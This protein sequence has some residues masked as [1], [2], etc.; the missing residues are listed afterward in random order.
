LYPELAP[1]IPA[2]LANRSLLPLQSG[3]SRLVIPG[4]DLRR[5]RRR[6]SLVLCALVLSMLACQAVIP[7]SGT[8]RNDAIPPGVS[9]DGPTAPSE[10]IPTPTSTQFAPFFTVAAVDNLNLRVHPG[11]LGPVLGVITEQT[12][13]LVIHRA[14]GGQWFLIRTANGNEGWVF[15][16]LLKSDENLQIAP[17][18]VPEGVQILHGRLT[19][20]EGLPIRGAGFSVS[21]GSGSNRQVDH[22]MT[23]ADGDFYS[24]LP[25]NAAG[26]WAIS[27]DSIA[28]NSSVW[29]G[30]NCTSYREGYTGMVEPASRE[31][32]LPQNEILQ[33]TWR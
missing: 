17:I 30:S 1:G 33:F 22:V 27:Y 8:T 32:T 9:A 11:Y 6:I 15:G 13:L 12:P 21:Q 16:A 31:V 14:P 28:C 23:D 10:D 20:L 19:D 25:E 24:F 4:D 2:R 29:A 26:V 3:H 18:L 5:M 7:P